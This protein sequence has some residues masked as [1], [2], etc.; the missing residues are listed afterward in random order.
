MSARHVKP[1]WST[2]NSM[3]AY[4]IAKIFLAG[5]IEQGKAVD[6]QESAFEYFKDYDV[7]IFNPRRSVWN[8][9]LEQNIQS[10]EFV[11]QVTWEQKK[12]EL[13]DIVL[14]HFAD[15]TLSPIS[16]HELGLLAKAGKKVVVSCNEKFWRQGNMQISC[17]LNNIPLYNSLGSALAH[18]RVLI[19]YLKA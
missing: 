4:Y 14:V 2:I 17:I 16:M 10:K 18:I 13:S 3:G 8:A 1:D 11:R 5:S 9:E 7:E 6:W 12:L 15:E 19:E